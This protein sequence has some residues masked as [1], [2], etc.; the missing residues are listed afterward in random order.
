[1]KKILY[2]VVVSLDCTRATSF[3]HWLHFSKGRPRLPT[4]DFLFF[5]VLQGVITG[6]WGKRTCSNRCR[7]N[8]RDYIDTKIKRR[9]LGECREKNVIEG[10][11]KGSN[12]AIEE[13]QIRGRGDVR[14][15]KAPGW[16]MLSRA[17]E[18]CTRGRREKGKNVETR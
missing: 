7:R 15:T 10:E 6:W 3:P 2:H 8:K 13:S 9:R 18:P 14:N 17:V 5:F 4:N 11:R 12:Q 16:Q 1:M